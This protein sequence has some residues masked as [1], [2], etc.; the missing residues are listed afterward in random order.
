[1]KAQTYQCTKLVLYIKHQEEND[2][3]NKI[4]FVG[5]IQLTACTAHDIEQAMRG[6]DFWVKYDTVLVPSCEGCSEELHCDW[7]ILQDRIQWYHRSNGKSL[8][9]NTERFKVPGYSHCSGRCFGWADTTQPF[10]SNMSLME[11]QNATSQSLLLPS[12]IPNT[13]KM[14]RMFRDVTVSKRW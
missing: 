10:S 12:C 7:K 8:Q 9:Q 5:I 11:G 6:L 2:I 1:M 14:R 3:S 4:V 13:W